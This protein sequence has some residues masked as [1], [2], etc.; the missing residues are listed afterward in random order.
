MKTKQAA[1]T[2]IEL[3]VSLAI[4]GLL[5]AVAT[6]LYREY[7][8][9]TRISEAVSVVQPV[10]FASAHACGINVLNGASPEQLGA[11]TPTDFATPKVVASIAVSDVSAAGLLV[12]IVLKKFGQVEAG[13]TLVYKGVCA[14][15]VMAWTVDPSSTVPAKLLPK[16][17]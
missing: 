4:V 10:L 15:N 2:L 5:A 3:L 7:V 12:T 8:D 11:G 17:A 13:K 16:Q 14:N 9:K 6:P 1:F